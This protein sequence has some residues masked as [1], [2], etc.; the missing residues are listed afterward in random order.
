MFSSCWSRFLFSAPSSI[1]SNPLIFQFLK[2]P[3]LIPC[4][5]LWQLCLVPWLWPLHSPMVLLHF[6]GTVTPSSPVAFFIL[7]CESQ[8]SYNGIAIRLCTIWFPGFSPTCSFPAIQAFLL[9]HYRTCA[10]SGL[11]FLMFPAYV[12]L[13]TGTY[14]PHFLFSFF[15]SPFLSTLALCISLLYF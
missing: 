2:Q 14:L 15:V 9:L 13:V 12:T 10:A 3:Y 7:P 8:M 1:L 11:W 6:L 5:H 4:L